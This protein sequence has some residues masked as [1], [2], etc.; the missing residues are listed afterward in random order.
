MFT[1][2]FVW[3]LRFKRFLEWPLRGKELKG[4]SKN[5][6]SIETGLNADSTFTSFASQGSK[7]K[8]RA[9]NWSDR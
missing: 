4:I 9:F 6:A 3:H 5:S 2:N 7:K 1:Q 8:A